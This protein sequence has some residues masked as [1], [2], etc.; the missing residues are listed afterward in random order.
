MLNIDEEDT[1]AS[2]EFMLFLYMHQEYFRYVD[3]AFKR[4]LIVR[5]ESD[6]NKA[7]EELTQAGWIMLFENFYCI[8][9]AVRLEGEK[10]KVFHLFRNM[11]S[12]NKRV[13]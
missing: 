10:N 11:Y 7:L 8:P 2:D 3:R 12:Y 6:D 1:H 9:K 13:F 4:V 5:K